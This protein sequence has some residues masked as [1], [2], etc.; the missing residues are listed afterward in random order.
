[1]A[2][3]GFDL[4]DALEVEENRKSDLGGGGAE[5]GELAADVGEAAAVAQ[6]EFRGDG[7]INS[8]AV[9]VDAAFVGDPPRVRRFR[10]FGLGLVRVYPAGVRLT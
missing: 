3:L 9:G 10:R 2:G 6:A 8:V 7:V 1:M 5:V 4:I